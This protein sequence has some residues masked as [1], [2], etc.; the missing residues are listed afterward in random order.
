MA[1]RSIAALL[2]LISAAAHAQVL[3]PAVSIQPALLH[4]MD[5][6]GPTTLAAP[7]CPVV[8]SARGAT[9]QQRSVTSALC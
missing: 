7:A 8:H 3:A 6:P 1:A 5:L 9:M 2:L 4:A